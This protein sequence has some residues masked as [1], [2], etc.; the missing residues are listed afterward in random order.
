MQ[1]N[2]FFQHSI[3][4][5]LHL[6]EPDGSKSSEANNNKRRACLA[7]DGAVGGDRSLAGSPFHAGAGRGG[8]NVGVTGTGQGGTKILATLSNNLGVL[9]LVLLIPAGRLGHVGAVSAG[10]VA[11]HGRDFALVSRGDHGDDTRGVSSGNRHLGE[12]CSLINEGTGTFRPILTRDEGGSGLGL[13]EGTGDGGSHEG[14][15]GELH[16]GG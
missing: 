7:R 9:R 4:C 8:Q 1:H 3:A 10:P 13:G 6:E 14:E 16:V 5:Q 15:L 2:T 11:G 12:E